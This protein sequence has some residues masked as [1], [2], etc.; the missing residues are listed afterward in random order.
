MIIRKMFWQ[1]EQVKVDVL[2]MFNMSGQYANIIITPWLSKQPPTFWIKVNIERNLSWKISN[3]ELTNWDHINLT[4]IQQIIFSIEKL[5]LIRIWTQFFQVNTVDQ[6]LQ[7]IWS[8]YTF[9]KANTSVHAKFLFWFF[10]SFCQGEL[11]KKQ[12]SK[13]F[14]LVSAIFINTF[15]HQFSM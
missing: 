1:I 9:C 11:Q 13:W 6:L 2:V 10:L 4:L 5:N 15:W 12:G 7:K 3:P 8:F 14:F